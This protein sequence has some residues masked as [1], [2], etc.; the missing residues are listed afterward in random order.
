MARLT[1]STRASSLTSTAGAQTTTVSI[2]ATA[3]FAV[4]AFSFSNVNG[5]PSSVTLDGQTATKI[6][7]NE[8]GGSIEIAIYKVAN[9]GT[10]ASKT[11]GWTNP[12]GI[13]NV[14]AAI[15]YRDGTPTYGASDSDF[16]G[17]GTLSSVSLANSN[18]D[19]IIA[20]YAGDASLSSVGSGQTQLDDTTG[21]L[22]YGFTTETGTG[23]SDTQQ[24]VSS[25]NKTYAVVVVT[26]ST[27][28]LMPQALLW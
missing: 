12:S 3:T 18:G 1:P 27:D 26:V 5:A 16:G 10:G 24:F 14:N 8:V 6:A 19:E 2:P 9:F 11:L 23:V 25:G 17:S 7:S 28:T 4:I 21:S 22:F 20:A 13:A 15:E